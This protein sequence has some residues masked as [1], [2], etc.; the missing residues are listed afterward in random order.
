MQSTPQTTT[1]STLKQRNYPYAKLKQLRTKDTKL[2]EE[3]QARMKQTDT[4]DCHVLPIASK[5]T[6]SNKVLSSINYTKDISDRSKF[7][8][9]LNYSETRLRETANV[10]RIQQMASPN[11][12]FTSVCTDTLLK[13]GTEELH[14]HP[15]LKSL[16]QLCVTE[17]SRAIYIDFKDAYYLDQQHYQDTISSLTPFFSIIDN[18]KQ[19]LSDALIKVKA[20]RG[21]GLSMAQLSEKRQR[22]LSDAISCWQGMLLRRCFENWRRANALR[23]QQLITINRR[24]KKIWFDSWRRKNLI[25]RLN[26]AAKTN[27][28]DAKEIDNLEDCCLELRE[29]KEKL[30]EEKTKLQLELDNSRNTDLRQSMVEINL[31]KELMECQTQMNVYKKLLTERM[32]HDQH[33]IEKNSDQAQGQWYHQHLLHTIYPR[34]EKATSMET[35]VRKEAAKEQDTNK[36]TQDNFKD[37]DDWLDTVEQN[38]EHESASDIVKQFANHH[39]KATKKDWA[40]SNFST[41][42]RD[43]EAWAAMI[44]QT[45]REELTPE[46]ETQMQ[47]EQKQQEQEQKEREELANKQ[48]QQQEEVNDTNMDKTIEQTIEQNDPKTTLGTAPETIGT[49]TE[50][51]LATAKNLTHYDQVKA[52]LDVSRRSIMNVNQFLSSLNIPVNLINPEDILECQPDSNFAMMAYLFLFQPRLQ[53]DGSVEKNVLQSMQPTSKKEENDTTF[54]SKYQHVWSIHQRMQQRQEQHQRSHQLY[55]RASLKITK[56]LISEYSGRLRGTPGFVQLSEE[57]H[58]MKAYTSIKY[59]K[60]KDILS[61]D[62]HNESNEPNGQ[63]ESNEPTA[64]NT[65]HPEIYELQKYLRNNYKDLSKIF[66][67]YSALGSGAASTISSSE[68]SSLLKDI[69]I[70]DKAFTANDAEL[71]FQRSNWEVDPIT[72]ELKPSRNRTLNS[73]EFVECLTRC[74]HSR[75]LSATT[76]TLKDCMEILFNKNLLPFAQRSDVEAFRKVINQPKIQSTFQKYRSQLKYVFVNQAGSDGVIGLDEFT[77]FLKMKSVVGSHFPVKQIIKIFNNVQNNCAPVDEGDE[78]GDGECPADCEMT[79]DEFLEALCAVACFSVP[80]PYICLEQRLEFFLLT[81]IIDHVTPTMLRKFRTRLASG[82]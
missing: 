69:Q 40:I 4:T 12:L 2:S 81:K 26:R 21:A 51:G 7:K 39:L 48:R 8:S 23:K 1:K 80:D 27:I 50:E 64:A 11:M 36:E 53:S 3:I 6:V 17:I 77:H 58:N 16:I 9:F 66:Q 76:T 20:F 19:Q 61:T 75:F 78:M 63:N 54:L 49:S 45:T 44:T 24:L 13:L 38:L 25:S 79:Y 55:V 14:G 28:E 29:Q 82:L 42:L 47:E 22:V 72:N 18:Q 32:N 31:R 68:F 74:A 43:G 41:N 73:M 10:C 56:F 65:T 33:L 5:H 57:K 67:S 62:G 34:E 15:Q 59:V 37:I 35:K 71:A 52:E 46:Q 30:V 60:I 70:C